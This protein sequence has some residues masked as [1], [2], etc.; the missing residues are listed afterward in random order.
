MDIYS[1]LEF[2]SYFPN[3]QLNFFFKNWLVEDGQYVKQGESIYEYSNSILDPHYSKLL[4]QRNYTVTRH[5]AEKSGY[6]DLF[7]LNKHS[8]FI[9]KSELMYVIREN[10]DKRIDRKFINIPIIFIDEFDNSKKIT[11]E[12]V[13]SNFSNSQGIKS[14]SDDSTIELTFSFN[15]EQNNDFIVFIF[16]P[17][18][19]KPKQNDKITLLFQ[20]GAIIE[21]I[22]KTKPVLSKNELN[23]KVLI[24]KIIITE[25]DLYLFAN[26]DLKKWK[27]TLADGE[28]EI[29]GGEIGGCEIYKTK[30]N[31]IIAIKK[32]VKEYI[33]L[34]KKNIP[35]HQPLKT[36][37]VLLTNELKNEFCFVYLMNDTTNGYYKIGIS[38]H[39][40]YR[41][42]TLQSE[43]PT[44]ELIVAKKFP[45]RKIAESFEKS[46]HETFSEKRIRGEWFA[47]NQLDIEH[48]IESLK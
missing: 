18:Q 5:K 12:R 21:F 20:N 39:P 44:I 17:K 36:R 6:I 15:F 38:N 47:L 25:N 27:I 22:L 33:D 46:L 35:E 11:W 23:N 48:I 31:Q 10:D 30:N 41:E 2:K 19:I 43:K 1:E 4:N 37:Q 32:F 26:V 40:K 28:E 13:S 16:E 7:F 45:I 14:K 9:S 8:K 34:V 3:Y 29:L 24:H 42:R